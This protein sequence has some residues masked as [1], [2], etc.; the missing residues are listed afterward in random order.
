MKPIHKTAIVTSVALTAI[1]F[2]F[3]I[4]NPIPQDPKYHRFADRRVVFGIPNA[5]DVLSNVPFMVIG[6]L[7][8][9]AA[10]KPKRAHEFN[11]IRVHY[12]IFFVG[13]FLTGVG[14]MYY[15]IA[16]SNDTLFWDRLPM[17]IAMTAFFCSV[18][19]EHGN[20]KASV[21]FLPPLLLI[22][23]GS[24]L[25][26]SWSEARGHGDLRLYGLVQYLPAILIP[27][28]LFLYKSPPSYLRYLILLFVFYSLAKIAEISDVEI[29][30]ALEMLSGHTL[31][32]LL[33]AAGTY[34]ILKMLLKRNRDL[35]S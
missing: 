5:W 25:Y 13:V 18:V 16:S 8:F 32:H 10:A 28:I 1:I 23:I 22:G 26:W 15:H 24:V 20:P 17:T 7:G 2:V 27:L 31:K 35:N 6:V 29:F 33:S 14:S 19:G 11:L 3:L 4:M 12:R 30:N 9:F 21:V 34:C